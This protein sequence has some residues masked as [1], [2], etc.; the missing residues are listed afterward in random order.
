M[1]QQRV[2]LVF[3]RC[4]LFS[5]RIELTPIS[6]LHRQPRLSSIMFE[7]LWIASVP[8]HSF[9]RKGIA[10]S[11]LETFPSGTKSISVEVSTPTTPGKYP[12]VLVVYGTDGLTG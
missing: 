8:H 10:M 2:I 12:A 11:T 5:G 9:T 1:T 7:T 6:H 4:Q 3:L